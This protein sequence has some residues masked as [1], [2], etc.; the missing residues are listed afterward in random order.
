L[1]INSPGLGGL[2]I[3]IPNNSKF[4]PGVTATGDVSEDAAAEACVVT[5]SPTTID[6]EQT[7][8]TN[9]RKK[10]VREKHI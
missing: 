2:D 3:P 7:N 8:S 4:I 6:P 5:P 1:P 10:S 9:D